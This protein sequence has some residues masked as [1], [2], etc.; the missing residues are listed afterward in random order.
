[1]GNTLYGCEINESVEVRLEKIQGIA[2]QIN[3][4]TNV[5]ASCDPVTSG[6]RYDIPTPD[7]QP[8]LLNEH[9]HFEITG[10]SIIQWSKEVHS[11][12]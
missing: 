2:C 5:K 9:H 10:N 3:E 11:V 12:S 6:C 4:R 8:R 7:P 1:M